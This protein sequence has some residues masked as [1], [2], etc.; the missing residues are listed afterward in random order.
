LLSQLS[1][2]QLCAFVVATIRPEMLAQRVVA[3]A[4]GILQTSLHAELMRVPALDSL[5][6]SA[7]LRAALPISPALALQIALESGGVPLDA[8]MRLHGLARR[9]RVG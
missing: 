9:G 6:T 3:D 2:S 4:I 7:M 5:T 1:Q 8:L